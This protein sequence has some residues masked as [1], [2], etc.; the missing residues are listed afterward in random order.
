MNSLA[1]AQK[2]YTEALQQGYCLELHEVATT[3]AP[4]PKLITLFNGILNG[5][6]DP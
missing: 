4:S 3:R 6:L 5:I 1:A 2:K